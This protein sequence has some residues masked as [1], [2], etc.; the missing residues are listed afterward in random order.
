MDVIKGRWKK[1]RE[2]TTYKGLKESRS[3]TVATHEYSALR[4]CTLFSRIFNV[5]IMRPTEKKVHRPMWD[6][7][8][9]T[10]DI[11]KR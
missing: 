6:N 2:K 1:H 11:K 3:S 9:L 7:I 10:R 8:H 4:T 5:E